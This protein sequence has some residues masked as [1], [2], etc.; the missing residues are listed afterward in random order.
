M[1]KLEKIKTNGR[2]RKPAR[3]G[4]AL[5]S[6]WNE[7][8]K[9][10]NPRAAEQFDKDGLVEIVGLDNAPLLNGKNKNQPICKL[11]ER[12]R[13]YCAMALLGHNPYADES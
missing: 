9:T 6:L 10:L 7:N 1:L 2:H 13:F 8:A 12:G 11:T 5:R 3:L 4:R